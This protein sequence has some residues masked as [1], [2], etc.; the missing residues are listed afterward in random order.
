MKNLVPS[1]NVLNENSQMINLHA[2]PNNK[3]LDDVITIIP[4][5][6]KFRESDFLKIEQLLMGNNDIK[7]CI[8]VCS[9][10]NSYSSFLLLV[11]M[12]PETFS[13][14][15][16]NGRYNY[17]QLVR[18]AV[19]HFLFDRRY[20]YFS[21]H[22]IKE[23]ISSIELLEQITFLR[24]GNNLRVAFYKKRNLN[25]QRIKNRLLSKLVKVYAKYYLNLD[26]NGVSIKSCLM[27]T[28]M[29][30]KIYNKPLFM[31]LFYEL[32]I[33]NRFS[34]ILYTELHN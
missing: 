6:E 9:Y 29:A 22:S 1:Y 4:I 10:S 12:Y 7:Y 17:S 28:S 18:F 19:N 27:S 13:I 3:L 20:N 21:I 23:L 15:F 11:N 5:T 33:L 25:N 32:L 16:F 34:S 24:N 26:I 31:N 14:L 2:D 30:G 8:S